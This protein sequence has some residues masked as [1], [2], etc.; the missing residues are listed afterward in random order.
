MSIPAACRLTRSSPRGSLSGRR[1]FRRLGC[2]IRCRVMACSFP[3]NRQQGKAIRK[4]SSKR[5]Q[6]R[7]SVTSVFAALSPDQAQVRAK[8]RQ[9]VF[10]HRC[11]LCRASAYTRHSDTQ[12]ISSFCRPEGPWMAQDDSSAAA[13]KRGQ[14]APKPLVAS[15]RRQFLIPNYSLLAG[16]VTSFVP[17]SN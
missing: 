16:A 2:R 17:I 13:P 9:R 11:L 10:G 15:P 5:D 6:T 4:H 1:F 3:A 8:R 14:P 12:V 7:K